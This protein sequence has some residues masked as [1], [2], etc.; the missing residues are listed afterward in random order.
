MYVRDKIEG[1]I[2]C[3]GL[4]IAISRHLREKTIKYLRIFFLYSNACDD[5]NNYIKM[6]LTLSKLISNTDI[7][8]ESI[9]HKFVVF[10][11]SFLPNDAEFGFIEAASR[12]KQPISVP[13]N[14]R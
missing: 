1:G 4:S 7:T 8:A 2:G 5:Q 13:R 12:K 14:L 6:P 11:H 9:D 10:R 3:Q